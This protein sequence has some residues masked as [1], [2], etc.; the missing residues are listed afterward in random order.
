MAKKKIG[1]INKRDTIFI[2]LVKLTPLLI[3]L[4]SIV[5][6]FGFCLIGII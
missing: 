2:K 4:G 1:Y 6:I 5:L 3:I